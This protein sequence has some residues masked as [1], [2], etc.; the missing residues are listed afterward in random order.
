[1]AEPRSDDRLQA[2]R[3]AA[4]LL[5]VDVDH[6]SAADG[7][8]VD[9]VSS[10]RLVIDAE[11]AAILA[12]GQADLGKLNVAVQSLIAMLPAGELPAPPVSDG[13]SPQ[14]V[15]WQTYKQMRDRGALVGEGYDGL[16][17]T[18][19]RL[20]TENEQLKAQLAGA[21]APDEA[22]LESLPNNVVKLS[23]PA[24]AAPAAPPKSVPPTPPTDE[25]RARALAIANAPVP[26]H[27][28][29]TRPKG[30]AW[31]DHMSSAHYDRWANRNW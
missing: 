21:P 8:R 17:C 25:E 5:G 20:K 9:M 3:E 10:L 7:L 31:R 23:P 18:V 1:M 11:Q 4:T 22:E 12:G 26:E 13:P 19:E 29:D 2:R 16:K 28:R 30:E 15:M 6:L 14:E 27:I 24:S